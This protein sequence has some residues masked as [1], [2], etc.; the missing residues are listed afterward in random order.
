MMMRNESESELLLHERR[1]PEKAFFES[2]DGGLVS[3]DG[4]E[5]YFM[6]I[7]DILTNFG[8]KKKI[9]NMVRSVV[10]NSRTISCIPPQQY[11]DRFFRFMNERVFI[12]QQQISEEI[13]ARE[14]G[15]PSPIFDKPF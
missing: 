9:E 13:A 4:T 2:Q 1:R 11:G 10:H 6:G 15:K 8:T 7:I 3:A 5:I 12:T 14:K